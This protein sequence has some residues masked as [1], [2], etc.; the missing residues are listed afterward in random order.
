MGPKPADP[1]SR[2]ALE[3]LLAKRSYIGKQVNVVGP[4]VRLVSLPDGG[5]PMPMSKCSH[6]EKNH[7]SEVY[8]P[9]LQL[10][11]P[12]LVTLILLYY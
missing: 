3:E 7:L 12:S 10:N 6:L 8:F 11:S 5:T 9:S 1:T 4:D 2:G